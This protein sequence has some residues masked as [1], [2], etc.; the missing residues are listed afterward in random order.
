VPSFRVLVAAVAAM[1]L[2]FA[3]TYAIGEVGEVA[4]IRTREAGGGWAETKLWVVDWRGTPWVRV[5]R[6]GRGWQR[7]LEADPRVELE[8]ADGTHAY[9]AELVRDE[10]TRAA[11]DAAFSAKY[12]FA[13]R[14]YG[15][16]VRS[17]P[18]PV[19]LAPVDDGGDG[20]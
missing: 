13:D 19:R 3:G 10:A 4:R 5:A 12:G 2:F 8:R 11:L 17:E 6:S 7:R 15:W 14:L 1:L 20:S 16:V 18:V 9:H